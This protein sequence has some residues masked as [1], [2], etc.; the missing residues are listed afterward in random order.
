MNECSPVSYIGIVNLLPLYCKYNTF[1]ESLNLY[2][3]KV[4]FSSAII[5]NRES[6]LKIL[7][8]KAILQ[9][10][11]VKCILFNL[12]KS[13]VLS[14]PSIL[15]FNLKKPHSSLTPEASN[16]WYGA[17]LFTKFPSEFKQALSMLT[18]FYASVGNNF[19]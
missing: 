6:V 12:T 4:S 14:T 10:N 18:I 2:N 9:P 17:T 13:F 1:S 5:L 19:K 11:E 16:T 3:S 8:L 7:P 15:E